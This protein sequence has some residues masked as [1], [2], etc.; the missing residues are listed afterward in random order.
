M[1]KTEKLNYQITKKYALTLI[2]E[3]DNQTDTRLILSNRVFGLILLVGLETGARI[4][5]I[6]KLKWDD[7]ETYGNSEYMLTYHN[8]KSKKYISIPLSNGLAQQ[9]LNTKD[10]L[11]FRYQLVSD[12]IF[13]NYDNNKLFTRVWA[14]NRIS[15]ANKRGLLGEIIDVAGSHSLRRTSAINVYEKSNG[16]MRIAS[17]LL[18]HKN[19]VTTSNYLQVNEKE[20]F[21]KLKTILNE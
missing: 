3:C 14:S 9:I 19:L 6:L 13:Y 11:S 12:Y 21:S 20:M 1:K 4:S 10:W 16:D 2:N 5:D 18:G 8:S 17:M 7:I 15:Q